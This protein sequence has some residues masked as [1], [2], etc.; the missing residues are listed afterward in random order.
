MTDDLRVPEQLD[1]HAKTQV[2]LELEQSHGPVSVPAL[3]ERL[4]I[5]PRTIRN[6]VK[7]LRDSGLIECWHQPESPQ[8]RMLEL[9]E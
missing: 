5:A 4:D 3:Y 6:A 7:D 1:P 9:R 2:W 8:H